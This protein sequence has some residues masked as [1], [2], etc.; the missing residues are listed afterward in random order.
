MDR[1]AQR[2]TQQKVKGGWGGGGRKTQSRDSCSQV[3]AARGGGERKRRDIAEVRVR[4][5]QGGSPA[6]PR[7]QGDSGISY[8]GPFTFSEPQR[9]L[10]SSP[11]ISPLILSECTIGSRP[12]WTGRAFS[13]N[14]RLAP[15]AGIRGLVHTSF[16]M[17]LLPSC[18]MLFGSWHKDT[19]SCYTINIFHSAT[20]KV[21][22]LFLIQT[23]CLEPGI[24]NVISAVYAVAS[25]Q[26]M[27]LG[28][29]HDETCAHDRRRAHSGVPAY[30]RLGVTSLGPSYFPLFPLHPWG[31]VSKTSD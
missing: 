20:V 8:F 9:V 4:G 10:L 7:V 25:L 5:W 12:W 26:E 19:F 16:R 2:E 1:T 18:G 27:G 22:K 17:F 21:S 13:I 23:H 11:L 30:L 24:L 3:L 15:E 31:S 14:Q 29:L 6:K 28:A